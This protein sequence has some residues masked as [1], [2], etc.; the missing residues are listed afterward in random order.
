MPK[1]G[2][3]SYPDAL[4]HRAQA[5]TRSDLVIAKVSLPANAE[6]LPLTLHVEGASSVL[7]SA[8]SS[9]HV[10]DA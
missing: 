2:F 8:A 6:N 4:H 10:F 9:V 3:T 7:T 5:C 1:D